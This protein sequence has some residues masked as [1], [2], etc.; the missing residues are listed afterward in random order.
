MLDSL[1]LEWQ[2]V[3]RHL[4]WMLGDSNS[5]PP[6]AL[7]PVQILLKI[8][9][10]CPP[11]GMQAQQARDSCLFHSVWQPY[12]LV[13]S[14]ACMA[15]RDMWMTW[16]SLSAIKRQNRQLTYGSHTWTKDVNVQHW[17][18][19][20]KMKFTHNEISHQPCSESYVTFYLS[21]ELHNILCNLL[22]VPRTPQL[23]NKTLDFLFPFLNLRTFQNLKLLIL[24][25]LS[26]YL[27]SFQHPNMV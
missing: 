9:V 14:V 8:F 13:Q 23:P 12:G 2:L 7:S 10:I 22:S 27:W 17:I 3:V 11:S 19:S 15:Y 6:E 4:A 16:N 18:I 1:R 21:P 24:Q 25:K 5:G 20:N 26:W